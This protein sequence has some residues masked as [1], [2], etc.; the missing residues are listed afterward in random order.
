MCP[1]L[2]PRPSALG[3]REI[4]ERG[5]LPQSV[6][7]IKCPDVEAPGVLWAGFWDLVEQECCLPVKTKTFP[8][9]RALSRALSL[10][11]GRPCQDL[12]QVAPT[13]W[14]C[15]EIPARVMLLHSRFCIHGIS[16]SQLKALPVESF[17][18][19]LLWKQCLGQITLPHQH[20]IMPQM[21]IAYR[22]S[23]ASFFFTTPFIQ[24]IL[25][26]LPVLPRAMSIVRS[27]Y[28][29]ALCRI[30]IITLT[31]AGASRWC[32][33]LTGS[34]FWST[35]SKQDI[36]VHLTLVQQ[37]RILNSKLCEK[38]RISDAS[39]FHEGNMLWTHILP[40]FALS[41]IIPQPLLCQKVGN[42]N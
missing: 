32:W 14:I 20:W 9:N 40:L 24:K 41:G 25:F 17:Q 11:K 6:C 34:N 2:T 3:C 16:A 30:N 39:K 26:P 38:A 36:W 28:I 10:N 31:T 8:S 7:L 35:Q 29:A 42:E 18:P 19:P 27:V 4:G 21:Q 13:I 15:E 1:H 12:E 37:A 5:F 33:V 22:V 23:R